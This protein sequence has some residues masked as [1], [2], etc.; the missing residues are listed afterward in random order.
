MS[1]HNKWS[2]IKHK[3]GKADA[4]RGKVFTKIIKEISV[5]ARSG[6]GDPDGNPRLR[7]AIDAAKAANMPKDNIDR[8]VKKGTGELEGVEYIETQYEGYG[9]GG[10][11]ILV[12]VLTDN[13]NRTVADLRHIFSRCNGNLGEAGCVSWMFASK[14]LI[15]TTDQVKDEDALMEAAIEAGAEDVQSLDEGGFEITVEPSSLEDVA[16]ALKSAGFPILKAEMTRVPQTTIEVTGKT[17]EQVIRLVDLLDDH[18]DVQKVH[19]NFDISE[20]DMEALA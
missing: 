12:E 7:R 20:A 16:E 5:A 4:A 9:P 6:G 17:A 19:A 11:A 8:A 3:K 2:T 13:K 10:V 14:G 18:D 1:G 15:Q